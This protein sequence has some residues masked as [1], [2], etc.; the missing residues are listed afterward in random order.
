MLVEYL[1]AL[2]ITVDSD[3]QYNGAV[4]LEHQTSWRPWRRRTRRPTTPGR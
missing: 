1:H 4:T 2:G 3:Q